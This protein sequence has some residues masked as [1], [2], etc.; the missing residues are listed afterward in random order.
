MSIRKEL[1]RLGVSVKSNSLWSFPGAIR[2]SNI[3][4][5]G[6]VFYVD[7]NDGTDDTAHGFAPGSSAFATIDYAVG[8]CT[9]NN[10]DVIYVMPGHAETISTATGLVVDVA[11]VSIIGVGTGALRPTLTLSASA[12]TVSITA[13]NCVFQGFLLI[14]S[15]AGGVAVGI[16][17]AATALNLQLLD[18]EMQ[19]TIMLRSG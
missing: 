2:A 6:N 14:S 8:R 3:G 10:G 11:G 18:I 16:T 15:F 13:A 19:E 4:S 1:K 17:A 9:A 5:L 7:S 12:S